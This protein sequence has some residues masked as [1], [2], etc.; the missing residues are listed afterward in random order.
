MV[1][2]ETITIRRR[3]PCAQSRMMIIQ[4]RLTHIARIQMLEIG[5][6][7]RNSPHRNNVTPPQKI[8]GAKKER[9]PV[10]NA[11]T[12]VSPSAMIPIAASAIMTPR[13]KSGWKRASKSRIMEGTCE[14]IIG[15]A[16][17]Q[18]RSTTPFP[19]FPVFW[20]KIKTTIAASTGAALA[21]IRI[22]ANEYRSVTAPI[23]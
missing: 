4:G 12:I 11:R 15:N 1:P 7:L 16:R 9:P 22:G 20:T 17:R 5:P 23:V 6:S 2:T 10:K 13:G 8:Q 14:I 19:V 18:I 3:S 21:P